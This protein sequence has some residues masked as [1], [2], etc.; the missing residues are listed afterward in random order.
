MTLQEQHQAHPNEQLGLSLILHRVT[1][2][3]EAL[4]D[5]PAQAGTHPHPVTSPEHRVSHPGLLWT[6]QPLAKPDH[7]FH[8]EIL[9][10]ELSLKEF[11][12][13]PSCYISSPPP[14][15]LS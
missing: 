1:E 8:E 6:L 5:H 4:Q 7:P 2:V 14:L 12:L 15:N 13:Q 3:G 11:S 10:K 9:L